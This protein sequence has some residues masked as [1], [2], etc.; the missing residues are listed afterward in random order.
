MTNE[1]TAVRTIDLG[2]TFNHKH[3]TMDDPV[4]L[5]DTEKFLMFDL[6]GLA[7][8]MQM[9]NSVGIISSVSICFYIVIYVWL[10]FLFSLQKMESAQFSAIPTTDLSMAD[11]STSRAAASIFSRPTA[12][13]TTSG[14]EYAMMAATPNRSPG[15][16]RSS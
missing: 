16:R 14:S 2:L 13:P 4:M 11:S 7:Y 15:P 10:L 8:F 12:V 3:I 1:K 6:L 5:I 9:S